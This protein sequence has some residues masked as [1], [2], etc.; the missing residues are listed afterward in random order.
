M[1]KP[2]VAIRINQEQLDFVLDAMEGY[3]TGHMTPTELEM[4]DHVLKRFSRAFERVS[5][6][7]TSA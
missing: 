2:T 1:T 7:A 4:F 6:K 3:S 5:L